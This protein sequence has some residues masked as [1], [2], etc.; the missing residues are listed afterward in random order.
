MAREP[1]RPFLDVGR[2]RVVAGRRPERPHLRLRFPERCASSRV[3]VA[4]GCMCLIAYLI[5]GLIAG[6][7]VASQGVGNSS[8]TTLRPP[9]PQIFR[10]PYGSHSHRRPSPCL[11][12]KRHTPGSVSPEI[13][14][15]VRRQGRHARDGTMSPSSVHRPSTVHVLVGPPNRSHEGIRESHIAPYHFG[16]RAGLKYLKSGGA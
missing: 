1:A 2:H 3:S 6:W 15:P 7:F 8:A 12:G 4:R 13:F 11:G 5:L 16:A 10:P 14:E 9:P